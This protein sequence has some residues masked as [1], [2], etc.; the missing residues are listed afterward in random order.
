VFIELGIVTAAV[1]PI[2]SGW[3]S[4]LPLL[5]FYNA[6]VVQLHSFNGMQRQ[7]WDKSV[8]LVLARRQPDEPV[9]VLGAKT[10]KTEFDY[11]REGD[12]DGVYYVRNVRFYE[13]YFKRRG[14]PALA[15]SLRVVEPTAES[16]RGLAGRFRRGGA[17]VYILAGHHIRY[18][19]DA[20]RTLEQ[21]TRH[22]E[23]TPLNGTLVYKVA[24]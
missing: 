22:I 21:V 3:L 20:L 8:D 12:V 16:V 14:A 9:Y 17:T 19:G 13:Y 4:I 18:T 11:L 2:T 23:V 10:D 5:F 24:F 6:A 7:Q 15:A 1:F